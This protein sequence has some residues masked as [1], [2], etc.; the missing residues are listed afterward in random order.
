M[1]IN[2]ER[3][4][5][6]PEFTDVP[7]DQ[8]EWFLGHSE[9]VNINKGERI[10]E[11]DDPIDKLYILLE[12]K[13]EMKIKRGN[14]YQLINEINPGEI[15]GFLPY[16][17]ATTAIAEGVVV[18]DGSILKLS[19]DCCREMSLNHYE[20]TS[21]FVHEMTTRT[22][23]FAKS[24]VQ[25]E[26]MMALGKLS[27]GLAHELNNPA[28]A[29]QRSAQ[30]LQKHLGNVPA[31]FKAVM[32]MKVNAD[33]VDRLNELIFAK[34]ESQTI[35]SLSERS[36]LEDE[37]ED[38]LD[39]NGVVDGF[40][41]IDSFVDYDFKIADLTQ[42][43]DITGADNLSPTLN[44]VANVLT[45]EKMVS[46]INE[47][48]HR[49]SELVKSVKVYTHMDSAPDKTRADLSKGIR[50]TLTMLNHKIKKK[51]IEVNINIEDD[52]AQ[53][54]VMISE[55]NQ[56]W[57]NLIDNA[58]DAMDNGGILKVTG[59]NAVDA[60]TIIIE[61]SGKGIAEENIDQIYD[62]F[63]TTKGIGEGT[64]MGLE[65]VQRIIQQHNGSI[66]VK[67]NPGKTQFFITIPTE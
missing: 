45:T 16:S 26:K 49:I 4:Y 59:E 31:K 12:G 62:P 50:S 53:P 47:A 43:L 21:V 38:W 7:P 11:V 25:A 66:D 34:L 3:I 17:R 22:R 46:E 30:E 15:S 39:D 18:E 67:S 28:S 48:S 36:T 37:M 58:I 44:W 20:L 35:L 1:K 60:V 27:A 55:I 8:I 6:I 29:I 41:L 54:C 23:E 13:I 42:I 32:S 64:G 65:V 57:T 9:V 10:F 40:L 5:A 51:S 14:N 2:K 19:K 33:Q 56:V 24:N 61:D 52:L 63:F